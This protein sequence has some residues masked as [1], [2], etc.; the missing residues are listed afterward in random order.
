MTYEYVCNSCQS[1]FKIDM[2][3]DKP[4]IKGKHVGARCT[5]CGSSSVR[6]L[7][8]SVSVHFKG[9]GFYLTDNSK[10]ARDE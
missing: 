9:R 4:I 8:N 10:E 2:P 3:I 5:I 7:I 6:K 1:R